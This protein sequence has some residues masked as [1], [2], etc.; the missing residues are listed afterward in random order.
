MVGQPDKMHSHTTGEGVDREL[1]FAGGGQGFA[2]PGK[3]NLVFLDHLK[4]QDAL[5]WEIWVDSGPLPI[6]RQ[7]SLTYKLLPQTPRFLSTIQTWDD[8]PI[9]AQATPPT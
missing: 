7:Y 2:T 8:S 5:D 3:E 6:P 1:W 9:A 4:N